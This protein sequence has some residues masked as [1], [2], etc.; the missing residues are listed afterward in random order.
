MKVGED[1]KDKDKV[2]KTK[3]K[4]KVIIITALLIAFLLL[5]FS[6]ILPLKVADAIS[7]SY[8]SKQNDGREYSVIGS[9]YS[10]AHDC[11]FVYFSKS[12]NS[13]QRNI[14]IYYRFLPFDVYFDSYYPG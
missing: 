11:Y 1:L 12:E 8:I 9:D 14:G 5:W 3:N 2:N 13:K 10:P 6:D 7:I 4:N